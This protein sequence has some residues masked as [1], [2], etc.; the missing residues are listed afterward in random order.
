[1]TERRRYYRER[2][3]GP[4]ELE[5]RDALPE[6]SREALKRLGVGVVDE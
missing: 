3:R 2:G 5:L 1:M 6:E 4:D